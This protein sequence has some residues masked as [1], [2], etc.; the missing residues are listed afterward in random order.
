[1]VTEVFLEKHSKEEN[2][3][4]QYANKF[5]LN[6]GS[7]DPTTCVHRLIFNENDSNYRKQIIQYFI[8]RGLGLC[9]KLNT[10]VAHLL[11]AW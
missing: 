7:G 10:F 2:M 5:I 9:I 4:I 6:M 1:M 3:K 8:M 11:Y